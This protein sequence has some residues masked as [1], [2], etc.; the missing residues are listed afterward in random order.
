M[1]VSICAYMYTCHLLCTH[2][3]KL[4]KCHRMLQTQAYLLKCTARDC[5]ARRSRC[6][7]SCRSRCCHPLPL[8][9]SFEMA[10]RVYE[11]HDKGRKKKRLDVSDSGCRQS[12]GNT[13]LCLVRLPANS[14]FPD[15]DRFTPAVGKG[16]QLVSAQIAL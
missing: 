3:Q 5:S 1:N 6:R 11:F 15:L 9:K 12:V 10:Y 14:Q 2:Q 13:A 7:S 4:S 16:N 8:A